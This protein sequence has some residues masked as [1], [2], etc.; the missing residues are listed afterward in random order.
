MGHQIGT[1]STIMKSTL[2]Y[3]FLLCLTTNFLIAQDCDELADNLN[4][5]IE[6]ISQ[7]PLQSGDQFFI[8]FNVTEFVNIIAFQYTFQF[9][10][11]VLEFQNVDNTGSQL[12]GPVIV[13]SSPSAIDNGYLPSIWTNGNGV[14]QTIQ[15]GPIFKMFFEVI[16]DPSDCFDWSINSDIVQ[17]EIVFETD[18]NQVCTTDTINYNF[19]PSEFCVDCIDLFVDYSSC[20]ENIEFSAC[21]G[22]EPYVYLLEGPNGFNATGEFSA[23]DTISFFN[24]ENGNYILNVE[25]SNGTPFLPISILLS[26]D[27][28]IIDSNQL[29]CNDAGSAYPS[30]LELNEFIISNRPYSIIDPNGEILNE[31]VVDFLG[32]ELGTYV[33]T[34]IVEG[35]YPCEDE[36]YPLLIEVIDCACPI[37]GLTQINDQCNNVFAPLN[38]NQFLISGSEPG[39]F[40]LLDQNGELFF[41]QPTI[42][43]L[44]SING[45]DEGIYTVEYTLTMPVVG[46]FESVQETILISGAPQEISLINEPP[47][48]CNTDTLGNVTIL[49]LNTLVGEISGAWIDFQGNFIENGIVD[50]NGTMAGLVTFSFITDTAIPPCDNASLTISFEVMDCFPTSVNVTSSESITIYPNPTFDVLNIDIETAAKAS[51]YDLNGKIVRELSLSPGQNKVQLEELKSGLYFLLISREGRIVESQKLIVE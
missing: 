47:E 8:E 41:T 45:L 11:D 49:D 9:D 23:T 25:E 22:T 36:S 16:G 42:D 39:T 37:I 10:N 3:F 51:V 18:D 14:A 26:N 28:V 30:T 38:L 21:G 15:D 34:Y 40:S 48:I 33:Y 20:S 44:L 27:E 2:L 43:G 12:I 31:S 17:V 13:N 46:C 19:T 35:P 5:N 50:F 7:G 32:A 24:L 1:R 29:V 6:V 4:W